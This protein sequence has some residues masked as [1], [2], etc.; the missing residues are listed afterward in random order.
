MKIQSSWIAWNENMES[1]HCDF[2]HKTGPKE[3]VSIYLFHRIYDELI[4][5]NISDTLYIIRSLLFPQPLET[6]F[7]YFDCVY[8]FLACRCMPSTQSGEWIFKKTISCLQFPLSLSSLLCST[9]SSQWLHDPADQQH[10]VNIIAPFS[11]SS[12]SFLGKTAY[13]IYGI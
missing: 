12:R 7:Y 13:S 5:W 9:Y 6:F 1:Y 8:W 3:N 2:S 4:V 10:K 11:A